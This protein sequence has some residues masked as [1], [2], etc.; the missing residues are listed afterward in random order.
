MKKYLSFFICIVL[1]AAVFSSCKSEEKADSSNAYDLISYTYDS[2]YS[3]DDAT[4]RAYN[5][6]CEAVVK[7]EE[8]LRLNSGML[9]DALQLFYTSFPLNSI[10][11]SITPT[12]SVYIIK[13]KSDEHA[14]EVNDF[15]NK[16]NE[17]QTECSSENDAAFTVKLYSCIASSI[18]PS[19]NSAISCYETIMTGEGTSFSYSN[20][21]EYIL[22]Q[23]GIK[24][25]HILCEKEDGSSKAMSA[26]ELGGEI[27]YFD[28]YAEYEDNSGKLLKYFGMTS[29]DAKNNGIKNMIYTNRNPSDTAS[30]NRF[31]ALRDCVSWK[32]EGESLSTTDSSNKIVQIAL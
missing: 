7:G 32:I 5:G 27:Y 26:A 4:I 31:E 15:I 2:A 17:I 8:E 25:Y 3:Y 16:K 22:Q 20:M 12:E 13:Y 14:N 28:L 11:E 6:I 24:A 9:D 21:F 29:E 23:R 1:A 19:D 30:D 18:K 10:V